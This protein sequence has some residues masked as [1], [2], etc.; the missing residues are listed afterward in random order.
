ME[1]GDSVLTWRLFC[2]LVV[3]GRRF[4]IVWNGQGGQKDIISAKLD[5]GAAFTDRHP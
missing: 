1:Q 2:G 5:Q 4:L 3:K